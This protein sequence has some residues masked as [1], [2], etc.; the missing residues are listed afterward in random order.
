MLE[1]VKNTMGFGILRG[2]LTLV[3][4]VAMSTSMAASIPWKTKSYSHF[5][6]NEELS[7]VI[8]SLMSSQSIPVVISEK[9]DELVKVHFEKY[10][11][12]KVLERLSDMYGLTWYYDGHVLFVYSAEEVVTATLRLKN[13]SASEFTLSLRE[14]GVFDPKFKWRM[15]E[16]D[17]VIYF[18]GPERF[19]NLVMEMAKVVDSSTK[20]PAS[21]LV[22]TWRDQSGQI[23]YSTDPPGRPDTYKIINLKTGVMLNRSQVEQF[24]FGEKTGY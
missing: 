20:K 3:L 17:G 23:N 5:S 15:S 8:T 1:V 12:Q 21:Q 22:Y 7:N 14:L 6:D 13:V 2:A 18:S 4:T 9:V 11:P 24:A 19:V 16:R 10:K